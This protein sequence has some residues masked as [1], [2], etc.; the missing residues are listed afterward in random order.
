LVEL[1]EALEFETNL[2]MCVGSF[3]GMAKG[4]GSKQWPTREKRSRKEGNRQ[5]ITKA[6]ENKQKCRGTVNE[7]ARAMPKRKES[8][9]KMESNREKEAEETR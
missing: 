7:E 8:R 1:A 5:M 6:T 2:F 9:R 3:F 4:A